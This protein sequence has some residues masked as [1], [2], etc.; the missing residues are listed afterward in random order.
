VEVTK[1]VT[2]A[3]DSENPVTRQEPKGLTRLDLYEAAWAEPLSRLAP[4]C[5]LTDVGLA[6]LCRRLNIPV[7][8]RGYWRKLETGKRVPK[9]PALPI[10][11]RITTDGIVAWMGTGPK[12]LAFQHAVIAQALDVGVLHPL[13]ALALARL[14]AAKPDPK[15]DIV[16]PGCLGIR[17][18]PDT[19]DRAILI[20]DAL[21]KEFEQ[22]ACDVGT[23]SRGRALVVSER[24]QVSFEILEDPITGR[25]SVVRDG[26]F[27]GRRTWS[28]GAKTR[29]EKQLQSFIASVE[30]S[31]AKLRDT[32]LEREER[33]AAAARLE[34]R[35]SE[36]KHIA[37]Q[38]RA[39]AKSVW[40][41]MVSWEK[42]TR[43]RTFAKAT[44]AVS[45][46]Q[47]ATPSALQMAQ[48]ARALADRIDPLIPNKPRELAT[49]DYMKFGEW[50]ERTLAILGKED[51][52]KRHGAQRV[53]ELR[54]TPEEAAVEI[55]WEAFWC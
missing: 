53:F 23:D 10:S 28:D 8:G 27:G 7:P 54:M 49:I 52:Y 39:A 29:V 22:K 46:G 9:R 4:K 34:K 30:T 41:A 35:N 42:A 38:E 11:S 6:K 2:V 19:I 18:L 21:V 40:R 15:Y 50:Y 36:R 17:V 5:C 48:T 1:A 3:P 32:R 44:E 33:E 13:T 12:R 16:A 43:L 26:P 25:L 31:L 37:E 45:D 14:R 20:A 51:G 24:D 47:L 55:D